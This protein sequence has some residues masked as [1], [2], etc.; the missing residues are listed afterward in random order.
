MA[1]HQELFLKQLSDPSMY[2]RIEGVP[3]FRPHQRTLPAFKG[4]DG[5]EWPEEKISVTPKDLAA[6]A[7]RTN[8]AGPQ[9]MT[10]GHRN[11]DP[12]FPEAN[13]PRKVGWETNHRAGQYV[14]D[15]AKGPEPCILADL[16]YD[17]KLYDEC[18]PDRFP[19]R[20]ADYDFREG[21]ISGLA[22]LI[23]RPFLELGMIPY[24]SYNNR[25][26]QYADDVPTP[27]PTPA[28]AAPGA[29]DTDDWTPEEEKQYQK[30]CRYMAK[31]HP[32]MVPYMDA[33][34][35]QIKAGPQKDSKELRGMNYFDPDDK[36]DQNAATTRVAQYAAENAALKLRLDTEQSERLLDT[37]KLK[38][39]FDRARELRTLVAL[40]EADRPGH[41]QYMLTTYEKL[42]ALGGGM[43]ET[44]A[45]GLTGGAAT[46]G[47]R[48]GPS[49]GRRLTE[50]Q[51]HAALQHASTPAVMAQYQSPAE[52]FEAGRT[53]ALSN[54]PA[55]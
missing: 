27:A 18:G 44:A 1:S 11:L 24:Q 42:P 34:Q 46:P 7:A 51:Y 20:S 2:K 36:D 29:T 13:Q 43:I 48:P 55:T 9:V 30:M 31:K 15:P 45:T 19:F 5:R 21:K 28:P 35:Y 39:K 47:Q 41:V 3:V 38:V 54:V 6:I 22:V 52:R 37:V 26:A 4:K 25:I 14:F 40:P 32:K 23:R 8:A 53:W 50:K 49:D 10:E 16:C 17:A 12:T 33:A